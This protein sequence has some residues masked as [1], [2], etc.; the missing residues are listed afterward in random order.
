MNTEWVT[1]AIYQSESSQDKTYRVK[2]NVRTGII[3]CNCPVWVY[4]KK[5]GAARWCK[6]TAR[7]AK[8]LSCRTQ[9]TST[10]ECSDSTQLALWNGEK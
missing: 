4:K 7:T 10:K 6:H 8:L 3:G 2:L 1:L 5:G 9:K